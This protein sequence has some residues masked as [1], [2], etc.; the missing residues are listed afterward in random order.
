MP[1][2]VWQAEPAAP[3]HR[4]PPLK[5]SSASSIHNPDAEKSVSR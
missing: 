3:C 1:V 5:T 4:W 2:C